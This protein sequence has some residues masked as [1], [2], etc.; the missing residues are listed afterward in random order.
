MKHLNARDK[1]Y[2]LVEEGL[3]DW[4]TLAECCLQ[5]MSCGDIE[6]MLLSNDLIQEEETYED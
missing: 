1:A 2:E 5:Y 4:K 3:T 6:D